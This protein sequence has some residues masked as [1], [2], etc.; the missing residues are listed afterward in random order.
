[1]LSVLPFSLLYLFVAACMNKNSMI[2]ISLILE[3]AVCRHHLMLTRSVTI[4]TTIQALITKMPYM[5]FL[6]LFD[7]T[8][9]VLQ[10]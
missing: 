1:M 6:L 3:G 10:A 2:M 9:M 7:G 4:A 8:G 5:L